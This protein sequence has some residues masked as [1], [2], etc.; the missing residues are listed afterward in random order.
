MSKKLIA[1]LS[2]TMLLACC[3]AV[4]TFAADE[5]E[6][7]YAIKDVMKK[8]MKGGLLKKV[9]GGEASAEEKEEL[10]A[11]LV[12]LSKA[13]PKKGEAES[14]EKLT[15]A[16]VEAGQ[17]AIDGDEKAGKMLEKAANCKACHE[18]HK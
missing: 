16:L 14:W 10:H 13:E 17:A 18:A 11:M 7:K 3:V 15:G 2:G 8:A 4:P 5:E 12:A 9:A 1:L 6:P